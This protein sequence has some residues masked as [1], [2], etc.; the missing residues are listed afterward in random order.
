MKDSQ[1]K[2]V[3][4]VQ[5]KIY[6]LSS[7]I[8]LGLVTLATYLQHHGF[9][10]QITD[11]NVLYSS[12]TPAVR[13][14][15]N[16]IVKQ[17]PL[18]I[19]FSIM[20]STLPSSLLIAKEC[21]RL[22]PQIPIVFGGPEVV[23]G[24]SVLLKTFKQ[25]DV[26]VRGEGEETLL[27]LVRAFACEN[28][29]GS[30]NG[31]T[32]WNNKI[33]TRNPDRQ[34]IKDVNELPQ[35]NYSTIPYREKYKGGVI[36]AGRGCPF[37][38]TFCST[39]KMWKK[40]FRIKSALRLAREIRDANVIFGEYHNP[41]IDIM[42]DNF[43]CSKKNTNK[44]LKLIKNEN[45]SWRCYSRLEVLDSKLIE[46]LKKAGCK[47]IFLGIESASKKIQRDIKKNLPINRLPATLSAL[48]KNNILATISLITGFPGE[49]KSQVNA[50]LMLALKSKLYSYPPK[51]QVSPLSFLKGSELYESNRKY[52]EHVIANKKN[53]KIQL[54][55][56]PNE[57][58]LIKKNLNTFIGSCLIENE[59]INAH[60]SQEKCILYNF[61]IENFPLT[62]LLL[63]RYYNHSPVFL[64]NKMFK[65]FEK[66]NN[67]WLFFHNIKDLV[68]HYFPTFKKFVTDHSNR[69]LSEVLKH[70]GVLKNNSFTKKT[71]L[72]DHSHVGLNSKPKTVKN[73]KLKSYHYNIFDIIDVLKSGS[74]KMIPEKKNYIAYLPG[75]V[76]KAIELDPLAYHL[77]KFSNGT[78]S[79]GNIIDI[80][81]SKSSHKE[82]SELILDEFKR[83]QRQ[84]LV[85]FE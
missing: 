63:L 81:D 78:L 49:S 2:K 7:Y 76:S 35:L 28:E 70:E 62:T 14:I 41:V 44:F 13:F 71:E 50:T 75:R 51:V 64:G 58:A 4:L 46:S 21:K 18:M 15:A 67:K 57:R 32:F 42:H 59:S 60:I 8:P 45:L 16:K 30:I 12:R 77:L 66:K 29:L 27:E 83:L 31:L 11:L 84:G 82:N 24:D 68:N 74:C 39:S 6:G 48:S 26:I 19:G 37:K 1:N 22:A 80:I 33:I 56:Q 85:L 9:D 69:L 73:L 72:H 25:I 54:T 17:K 61:L 23:T 3:T 47:E 65:Y 20:C 43:L 10:P 52:I 5:T 34:L 38:C 40:K 53:V 55:A 36:E 79:A